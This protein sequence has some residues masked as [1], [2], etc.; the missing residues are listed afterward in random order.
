MHRLATSDHR[1]VAAHS[2]VTLSGFCEREIFC[3][4]E[5]G[6]LHFTEAEKIFVCRDSLTNGTEPLTL[7]GGS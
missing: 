3:L 7:T 4:I 5:N 6:W 2:V 1:I